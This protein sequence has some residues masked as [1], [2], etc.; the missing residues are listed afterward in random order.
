[1]PVKGSKVMI[2]E[3]I[4]VS[5]ISEH[6]TCASQVFEEYPRYVDFE[7]GS[8]ILHDFHRK[9][10]GMHS[11]LETWFFGRFHSSL[12]GLAE[13]QKVDVPKSTDVM[14]SVCR[15]KKADFSSKLGRLFYFV[16]TQFLII[17]VFQEN[18]LN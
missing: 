18:S 10:K 2:D 9:Y 12:L 6:F 3:S 4:M 14:P 5:M 16:K 1:M 8:L 15:V 13:R 17:S 7:D 11:G